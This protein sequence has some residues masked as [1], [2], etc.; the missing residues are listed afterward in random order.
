MHLGD[1][2]EQASRLDSGLYLPTA[3]SAQFD[4]LVAARGYRARRGYVQDGLE[5]EQVVDL[6]HW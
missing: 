5:D 3:R 1:H 2:A 6:A 4:A